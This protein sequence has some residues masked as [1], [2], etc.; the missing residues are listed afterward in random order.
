MKVAPIVVLGVAAALCCLTPLLL[1]LLVS[2]V[3]VSSLTAWLGQLALPLFVGATVLAALLLW[4]WRQ[5]RRERAEQHR[6]KGV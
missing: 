4:L 5:P 2:V 1:P 6:A 3:S